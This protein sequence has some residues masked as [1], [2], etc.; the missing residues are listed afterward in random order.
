M[1]FAEIGHP[2]D[3]PDDPPEWAWRIG[4]LELLYHRSLM[5][6][7]LSRRPKYSVRGP[8]YCCR[9]CHGSGHLPRPDK[10]G[11]QPSACPVCPARRVLI[12][13]APLWPVHTLDRLRR[14][15]TTRRVRHAAP[16][17]DPWDVSATGP[18]S[19]ADEPPF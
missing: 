12:E 1:W 8:R 4:Y 3:D 15:R 16:P 7:T 5:T 11:D 10:D 2:Y 17:S 19:Y 6:L 13:H 14:W 18:A 9:L